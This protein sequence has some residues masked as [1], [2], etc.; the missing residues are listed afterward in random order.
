MPRTSAASRASTRSRAATQPAVESRA[1]LLVEQADRLVVRPGVS[2][3][4]DG[5]ERVVHVADG[6]DARLQ[7]EVERRAAVRVAAAVEPLV[8]VEHEPP[9]EIGE[10]A[11]LAEE[12]VPPLGM[13]L[14]DR[15]LLLVERAGLLE[16]LVGDG[17]L[18]D[19]VEQAAGGERRGAG[20]GASPS[21]SPTSTAR[22]A[23]R[24]VWPSVYSSFSASRS[25][26]ARTR[27]PRNACSAWTSSPARGPP[28]SE[29]EGCARLRSMRDRDPDEE[30]CRAARRRG[31]ATSRAA[32]S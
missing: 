31:R 10:P 14:D 30:R 2:V 24:R 21:S 19:V 1:G 18:A 13:P 5:E 8:V 25:V 23:T 16:D 26:S 17:E 7:V 28:V 20:S 22:R 27:A 4:A 12:L 11:E 6:E 32:C 29:R 3:D 15:E 9:H